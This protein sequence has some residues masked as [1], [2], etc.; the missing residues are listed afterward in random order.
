MRCPSLCS[1]SFSSPFLFP[2]TVQ[3]RFRVRESGRYPESDLQEREELREKKKRESLR[4]RFLS[5]FL[6]L[7][8]SNSKLGSGRRKRKLNDG[9]DKLFFSRWN[10]PS[11]PSSRTALPYSAYFSLFHWREGELTILY[12]QLVLE[13]YNQ[14][15]R[16]AGAGVERQSEPIKPPSSKGKTL[17]LDPFEL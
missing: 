15:R 16:G 11:P 7:K 4:A 14:A 12:L 6:K 5:L 3:R 17:D 13:S 2:E 10:G 1:L 8:N 9:K